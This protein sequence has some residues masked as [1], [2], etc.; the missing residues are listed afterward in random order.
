MVMLN[1]TEARYSRTR[2][3]ERQDDT[4]RKIQLGGL[5]KKANLHN[6]AT[7]VLLGLL[8]EAE[9]ILHSPGAVEARHRWRLKGDIALTMK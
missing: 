6:E 8:L 5:I 9:E 2:N 7:A 1:R 4:R 3:N